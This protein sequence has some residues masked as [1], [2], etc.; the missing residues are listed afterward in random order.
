MRPQTTTYQRL[1]EHNALHQAAVEIEA[2]DQQIQALTKDNM[3]LRRQHL[4][5]WLTLNTPPGEQD[6]TEEVPPVAEPELE[7]R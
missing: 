3:L 4:I 2:K 1:D 7:P 5:L 6:D